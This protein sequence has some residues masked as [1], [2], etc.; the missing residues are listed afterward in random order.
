MERSLRRDI[1]TYVIVAVVLG[2]LLTA[3][4]VTGMMDLGHWNPVVALGIASAKALLVAVFFMHLRERP[5]ILS[6]FAIA[7]LFWL[8]ILFTLSWVDF[9]TR[10]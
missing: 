9:S 8:A 5:G 10:Y 4:I 7:G 1:T 2:V 3:S 6:I